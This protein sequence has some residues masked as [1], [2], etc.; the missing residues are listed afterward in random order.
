M[1]TIDRSR[2]LFLPFD[3]PDSLL[4]PKEIFDRA[5]E[6]L[7]KR[8]PEDSRLERKP[9]RVQDQL[10][11]EYFSMWAN[12]EPNGGLIVVG[13]NDDG[14]IEGCESFS[15]RV[16]KLERAGDVYCPDARYEVKKVPVNNTKGERDFLLL[17]HVYYKNDRVVRN[18]KR[19]AFIRRGETKKKLSNEEIRELEIDRGQLD[20]EQEPSALPFP[21]DYDLVLLRSFAEAFR[22]SRDLTTDR[23]LEEILCMRHL[24]KKEKGGFRPNNACSLLF[25]ND[26]RQIFPGCRI[27]IQRFDG[28]VEGSGERYNLVK[29]FWIEGP[30]PTIL[31]DVES[32]VTGQLR[33]FSR[34]G[35][36]GKFYTAPEY[37]RE[38]WYEAVVNACVHRSY[39]LR[40]MHV[41]VKIF[42]DRMEVL[43]PGGF[44]PLVTPE[45]IFETQH[46]RNP[47][48]MDALYYLDIVKIANEGTRRMRDTMS[49]A[50]LPLPEF[51]ETRSNHSSV[52]VVLRN[53]IEQR[54]VWLDSDASAIVGTVVFGQLSQD[55]KRVVNWVAEHGEI[56]VSQAQ[57]HIAAK[58]WH[59]AKKL[60]MRLE[61]IGILEYHHRSD[62]ER[63][64]KA[65]F[66]LRS[67]SD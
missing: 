67:I 36:D 37:P 56:N 7:L 64:P 27:R 49:I 60:L 11:G 44:P 61:K 4:E 55:E 47:R 13:M 20:L 33:E 6:R 40:N 28:N 15:E 23:T 45:N 3:S 39:G 35:P 14:S 32:I 19:E 34:L 66:V 24:G 51:S 29:E 58:T 50:G 21:A 2:Q 30:V 5:S 8:L 48:L 57:R 38:A 43:S 9:A 25:A 18:V 53:N 16:N 41:Q 10:L 63:D 62:I 54:K 42:D 22:V 46:S 65:K 17:F 52:K 26:P 1:E 31:S 59:S 12:T